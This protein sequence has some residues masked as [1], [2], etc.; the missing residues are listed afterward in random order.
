[1]AF[2]I[3]GANSDSGAYQID[4]SLKFRSANSA[5]MSQG[6]GTQTDADKWTVSFW[7][8]LVAFA[9]ASRCVYS[10]TGSSSTGSSITFVNNTIVVGCQVVSET[11]WVGTLVQQNAGGYG[12]LYQ[13]NRDSL[14]K[15]KTALE[16]YGKV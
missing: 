7:I 9:D 8:K 11:D 12:I 5:Q 2:L 3:G 16:Q 4:N 10:A 15:V 6:N 1:M 14:S 13:A